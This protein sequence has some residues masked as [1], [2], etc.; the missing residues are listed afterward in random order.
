MVSVI[1]YASI[2]VILCAGF[3]L[4]H[5]IEKFPNFAH[6]AYSTIGTMFIFT[7]TKLWDYNPYLGWPLASL[8]G[9]VVGVGLYLLVVRPLQRRGRG[10]ITLS[11]AMLALSYVLF[12][13]LSTYSYWFMVTYRFTTNLFL[14]RS[15]DYVWMGYPGVFYAA[16]L[17]CV[18]IVVSLHLFLAR[19]KFG[20][21]LRATAEN[22]EL[23][24]TL[25]IN[26]FRI[27]VL[28]W[29][30]AGTMSAL[31]GAIIPLWLPTNVGY[32]D[33]LLMSVIAG[34]VL[35]GLDN[36]Y[37]SMLGGFLVAF[38]Q[39]VLPGVLRNFLDVWVIEYAPMIPMFVIIVGL[40]LNPKGITGIMEGEKSP[41]KRIRAALSRE[42]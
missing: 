13:I 14:L 32:A 12:A 41:L 30:L 8:L 24:V 34:S 21:A 42:G 11:F 7:F 27:H 36:V 2:L 28:S 39:R 10:E 35:G 19:S 15:Y 40:L 18:A 20:I 5:M 22:P 1:I 23:A 38:A 17:T 37:G 31:A 4:T 33:K 6:A 9:G 16:P 3:S 25:G 29:F 26:V